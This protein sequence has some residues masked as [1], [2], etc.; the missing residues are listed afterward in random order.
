MEEPPGT[1]CWVPEADTK[2][3]VLSCFSNTSNKKGEL[4]NNLSNNDNNKIHPEVKITDKISELFSLTQG[5][6]FGSD[7]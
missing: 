2:S 5:R 4:H 3:Y 7:I 6:L 1:I